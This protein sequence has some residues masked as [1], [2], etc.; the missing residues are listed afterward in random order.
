MSLQVHF[1]NGARISDLQ[2]RENWPKSLN[3]EYY[4]RQLS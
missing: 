4:G 2:T 3:V 1:M